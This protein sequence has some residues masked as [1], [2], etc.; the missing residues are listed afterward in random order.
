MPRVGK[1]AF[2]FF[3]DSD[4][5]TLQQNLGATHL[6]ENVSLEIKFLP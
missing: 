5:F 2:V 6:E 4:N 3:K 1:Q